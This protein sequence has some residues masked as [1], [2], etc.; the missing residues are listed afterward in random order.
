[1]LYGKKATL[2]VSSVGYDMYYD[3]VLV[4]AILLVISLINTLPKVK[5]ERLLH[6]YESVC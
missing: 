1:M 6:Q 2:W 4:S 5:N 3:Y